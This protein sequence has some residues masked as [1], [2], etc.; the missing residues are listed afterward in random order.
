MKRRWTVLVG[1]LVVLLC[2][3]M[4][5]FGTVAV[6]HEGHDHDTEQQHIEQ[7]QSNDEASGSASNPR[8]GWDSLLLPITGLA[9]SG[10]F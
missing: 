9:F 1:F 8:M 7:Q 5:S 2:T 6:A 4:P 3:I 10:A